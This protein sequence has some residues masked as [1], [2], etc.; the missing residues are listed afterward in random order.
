MKI[1]LSLFCRPKV[2]VGKKQGYGQS[3][4]IIWHQVF[5]LT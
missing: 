4:F 1:K 3:L 2:T 5:Q